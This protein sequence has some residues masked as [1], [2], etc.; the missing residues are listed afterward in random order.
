M[1]NKSVKHPLLNI[2]PLLLF[3]VLATSV[4][5][6]LLTGARIYGNLSVRR[7]SSYLERTAVQYVSVK[8]KQTSRL[9]S[10]VSVEDF[11]GYDAITLR[12]SIDGV[13]YLTRIYCHDGYLKELF[14]DAEN[15]MLPDDG[16]KL[17]KSD[18]LFA[19]KENG[20]LTVTLQI[21]GKEI[22]FTIHLYGDGGIN[23]E[24]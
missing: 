6:V 18:A 16:E 8:V 10:S 9:D 13:E 11:H 2:L 3:A 20:L 17:L 19:K 23:N 1:T 24:K 4:L 15:E 12:E 14:S 5:I 22:A 7:D 21:D